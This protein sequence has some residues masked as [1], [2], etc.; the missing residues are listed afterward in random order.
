MR[1]VLFLALGAAMMIS[2]GSALASEDGAKTFK[3]RCAAC[4]TVEA[5]KHK[6]GPSL[7]GIVGK[8]AGSSDF[9]RYKGLKGADF[10]WDEDNLDAWIADSRKFA[11]AKLG[12]KTSM[13]VKIK[14]EEEREAIIEFL[15]A[16]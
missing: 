12:G 14:K 1:K 4:H 13:S 7:A 15:E 16:N 6:S 11:K 9:K 2:S 5:G 10:T 8:K 3:K